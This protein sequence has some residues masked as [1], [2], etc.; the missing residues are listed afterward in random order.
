[1]DAI[2][3][4]IASLVMGLMSAMGIQP[5]P[6]TW[7]LRVM[8]DG[9]TVDLTIS[10]HPHSTHGMSVPIDQFDGL[11]PL[12][13]TSGP[14]QFRL[15]RDAGRFEFDGVL[16]GGAGGGT[17]EF[18]PSETFPVELAR[19]G[20]DK[21]TR[22]DQM[23]MAWHDTG[24]AFIDELA[25]QKYQRPT[26]EKLVSAGDHGVDRAYMRAMS[27]LGYE[28]GTLDA[29]VRLRDHGID[30]GYV[31][32]LASLGLKGL[33]ANDLVRARDHGVGQDY[34]RDMRALGYALTVDEL[35]AARDHG[36]GPEYV[37]QL[38][39]AGYRSP[40][41]TQLIALRDH[42]ITPQYARQRAP[43][44]IERLIAL[45]DRGL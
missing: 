18:V 17:M 19:R 16:R 45:H 42:G 33:T 35:V 4:T 36:V 9:K 2:Y 39:A 23:K 6:A 10:E 27:A 43:A 21:P 20:F 41:L 12:L 28:L 44:P 1:M 13:S 30:A 25:A 22:V 26:L 29:L 11:K 24:F 37:N 38:A 8:L 34:V 31:R 15:K 5:P 7:Q 32:D 40:S 14:A 3:R